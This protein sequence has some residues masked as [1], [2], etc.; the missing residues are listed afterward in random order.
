MVTCIYI[1]INTLFPLSCIYFLCHENQVVNMHRLGYCALCTA[2]PIHSADTGHA[3]LLVDL[4]VECE[5]P[6]GFVL[7]A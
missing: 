1:L 4:Q 2:Q 7:S 5:Q 3:V 6:A